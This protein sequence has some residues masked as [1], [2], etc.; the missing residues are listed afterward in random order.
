MQK[1]WE[2]VYE[3]RS[4]YVIDILRSRL[5]ISKIFVVVVIGN[6]RCNRPQ[7]GY[8]DRY[9]FYLCVCVLSVHSKWTK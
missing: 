1:E 6:V 5:N 8:D 7:D 3:H 4:E 9:L 2:V